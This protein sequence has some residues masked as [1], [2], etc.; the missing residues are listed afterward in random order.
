MFSVKVYSRFLT[1]SSE[2][3]SEVS[4]SVPPPRVCCGDKR[5]GP[6]RPALSEP[7]SEVRLGQVEK[8][9]NIIIIV[10]LPVP[11]LISK[12]FVNA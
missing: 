1:I 5:G 12:T 9:Q 6:P 4:A 7:L 8:T 3:G 11:V 10:S 2:R